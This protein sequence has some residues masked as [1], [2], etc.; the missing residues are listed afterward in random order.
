MKKFISI[1]LA[2][3]II[4]AM[5]TTAFASTPN[6]ENHSYAFTHQIEKMEQERAEHTTRPAITTTRPA[7]TT[8][9]AALEIRKAE[10]EAKRLAFEK[11]REQLIAARKQIL[12]QKEINNDLVKANNEIRKDISKA[13]R[14]IKHDA[15]TTGAL[16]ITALKPL[17]TSAQAILV[18]MHDTKGDVKHL[19]EINKKNISEKDYLKMAE[20]IKKI[21]AIQNFRTTQFKDMNTIFMAKFVI[22][23]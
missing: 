6:L 23:K 2:G 11:Y 3:S 19:A 21:F 9:K 16:K 20:E 13:L 18:A 14:I 1:L 7:I 10:Q 22:V 4:C 5:G 8:S 15:S 12:V 17:N